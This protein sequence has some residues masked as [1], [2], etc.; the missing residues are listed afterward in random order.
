MVQCE[1]NIDA[2]NVW[3]MAWRQD[4]LRN[5]SPDDHDVIAVFAEQVDQFQ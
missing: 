5:P 4:K 2:A 1:V 3:R